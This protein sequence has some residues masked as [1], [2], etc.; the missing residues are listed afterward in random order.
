MIII[1][2]KGFAKQLVEIFFQK[3]ET[4]NLFFFDNVSPDIPDQ[5]YGIRV[6]RNLDMVKQ[7]FSSISTKFCLGLGVPQHRRKL[8][9]TFQSMGGE[10]TSVISGEARIATHVKYLGKGVTI[11]DGVYIEN[12]VTI[13]DGVLLN[14]QCTIH[15]DSYVGLFSEIS[16]GARILGNCI[17]GNECIIGANAVILPK[18]TLNDESVVGAG[19]VVTQNVHA[20]TIVVGVP[21]KP[22]KTRNEA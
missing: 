12:D 2:A 16:P 17:I 5:L 1:G 22:L 15:H 21:A 13:E 14:S 10:L 8:T 11:L 9:E 6:L 19:A 20:Q 18:L 4:D 7:I 3:E